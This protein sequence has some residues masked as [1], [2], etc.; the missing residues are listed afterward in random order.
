MLVQVLMLVVTIIISEGFAP[1]KLNPMIG[2]WPTVLN[3]LGAKNA[4][5]ITYR[6]E[7]WRLF[8]PMLLH[9]GLIHLAVNVLIQLRVGVLLELQWGLKHFSLIYVTSGLTSSI[10]SCLKASSSLLA[11]RIFCH[12]R[13][14]SGIFA[15]S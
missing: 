12:I 13:C 1:M 6:G 7:L 2:P 5:L 10:M 4:A 9:A 14:M 8:T 15:L 3:S 11:S